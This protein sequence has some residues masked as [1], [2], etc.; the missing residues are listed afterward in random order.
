MLKLIFD[1]DT[2]VLREHPPRCDSGRIGDLVAA[3]R[4][5]CRGFNKLQAPCSPEREREALEGFVSLEQNL[6]ESKVHDDDVARFVSVSRLLWDPLFSSF[7]AFEVIPKHGPGVTSERIRGNSKYAWKLWHDRLEPYFPLLGFALPLGASL[8]DEFDQVAYVPPQ[9]EIPSRVILVPKTLKGPRIIAAEP[10]AAQYAQQSLQSFLYDKI[11]RYWLT[12]GR[13][14]FRDQ[15]INQRLAMTSSKTGALATLD[16]SDASDRVFNSLASEMFSGNPDLLGA[17]QSCRTT[18]ADI[19]GT[20]IGPLVKFASMGSALCFPVEAMY[21]FT[22]C[23]I[24]LLDLHKLPYDITSIFRVSRDVCVYGDDLI[25]PVDA[26][27]A[28]VDRLHKY[29]CKVNTHKSFWTGKFRESCG[30]DAY[31]GRL[32]TPTYIRHYVP[33]N[34]RQHTEIISIS[35]TA[36]AFYLRGYWRTAYFLWEKLERVLGTL[37]VVSSDSPAVGRIS[38]LPGKTVSR[39]NPDLMRFEVFAWVVEPVYRTDRVDGY[40]A[41]AKSL[42]ALERRSLERDLPRRR[43]ASVEWDLDLRL[44]GE[45]KVDPLHLERSARHGVA[46]L[47]RRAVPVTLDRLG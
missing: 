13:I 36:N 21:F 18:Y 33:Y 11:E 25:V 10:I 8:E 16:M 47:K 28:I 17:I 9:D 31:D 27:A 43:K 45:G 1:R 24:A 39:Y 5:I 14:N 6:A 29:H 3:V 35:A 40:A 12:S 41:L 23:I 7:N 32:V 37:P 4:Q 44:V 2:G 22:I 42:L 20:R 15:S 30:V 46:A 38:F 19:N 34:R 26:T